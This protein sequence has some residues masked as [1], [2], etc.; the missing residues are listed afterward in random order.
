VQGFEAGEHG[1]AGWSE[2]VC[3][4]GEYRG[5]GKGRST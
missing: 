5:P 4:E 1:A 2:R 3:R